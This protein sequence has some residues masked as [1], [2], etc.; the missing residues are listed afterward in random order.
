MDPSYT[1][2]IYPLA[3]AAVLASCSVS[4]NENLSKPLNIVYIMTDDH[5][6][7]MMSCYDSR[8]VET[9][10]IWIGSPKM[11]SGLQTRM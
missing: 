5:T 11:E 10:Q 6:R 9:P 3:G 2:L 7:Q 1:K 8:H 4:K